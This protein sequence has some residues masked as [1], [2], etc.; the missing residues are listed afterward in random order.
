MSSS[1]PARILLGR[2]RECEEIDEVVGRARSG[3]SGVVVIEG[4]AGVGKTA[5]LAYVAEHAAGFQVVRVS[6]V[7]SEAEFAYAGLH[8][9][10]LQF[11]DRMDQLPEPQADALAVALGLRVGPPPSPFIVSLAVLSLLTAA[12]ESKP[13]LVLVDDAHW[14]DSAS[15]RTLSFVARRLHAEHAVMVF[16]QR[17]DPAGADLL[18][19]PVLHLRGL[20]RDEA[21][22]LLDSVVIGPLDGQVRDRLLRETAGNP[23]AL[24]ELHR[25]RSSAELVFGS[26]DATTS[27]L[28]VQ[29][30]QA[31]VA[32]F[33]SLAQSTQLLLLIAALDP[34]GDT[35]IVTNAAELLG[36]DVAL[37]GVPA[38]DARLLDKPLGLT[39][40]VAF[41]HPL[42]RSA[43]QHAAAFDE[44]Q[45]AHRALA[46]GIDPALHP[47]RR[48]WHRAQA[49]SG[50]DA[51]VA[52][53]LAESAERAQSRGGLAAASV[54][55]ERASA[56]TPDPRLRSRRA[57][58]A[59][60]AA[61]QA[62][63]PARALTL[64]SL[65]ETGPLDALDQ[66]LVHLTRG[67]LAFG[68]PDGGEAPRLLLAAARELESLDTTLARQTYL[69]A[70]S[71]AMFAGRLAGQ[72]GLR[73]VAAA[74][75]AAPAAT[76]GGEPR[77]ALLDGF[78]RAIA[79]GIAAGAPQLQE[80]VRGFRTHD[81]DPLEAL[82]WLWP[83][84][85]AAHDLWDDAAWRELSDRHVELARRLGALHILPIA[86]SARIG[87][88]LFAGELV[89]VENLVAEV[90]SV[91]AATGSTLPPY[92]AVALAAWRGHEDEAT[93]LT[94]AALADAQKRGDGLG[95]T[96]V[97]HARAVLFNGLGRYQEAF[98]AASEAARHPEELAF[99]SWA[100]PELVE[101]AVR[102]DD[103]KAAGQ[104]LSA[105]AEIA[106]ASG[107]DWIGGVLARCR[108]LAEGDADAAEAHF[109]ESVTRLETTSIRL[110]LA[111]TTLVFGEWLRARGRTAEAREQLRSAHSLFRHLGTEAFA[112]RAR[113]E[114]AAAGESVRI[115][116]MSATPW[117]ALSAQEGQIA[118]LA[119]QGMTNAQ[120]GAD[121]FVSAR[122]VEWHL[123]KVYAKLGVG[124]RRELVSALR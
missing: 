63:D 56:L 111:R 80:A 91:T 95:L 65:A 112:D 18:G 24:L 27:A 57:Y 52:T 62:G 74:A 13:L 93:R 114:L 11:L 39:A 71:A 10:C 44:L 42:V 6:G 68:S 70:L 17:P 12:A 75:L 31:Y 16:A 28:G 116:T 78:A 45:T 84:T 46:A 72:V 64:L 35:A 58:A 1:E 117:D 120:I 105:L 102:I 106:D 59:A 48:A 76:G 20:D 113:R 36:I 100:L 2:R 40:T 30:E 38:L 110:A 21:A 4:A 82:R 121:L 8:L 87:L 89:S 122:T 15:A 94:G 47:D 22:R 3:R 77:D 66:A 37:A 55:L 43:I 14:L 9:A 123:S 85:H 109:R 118:R 26:A 107:T 104:A 41:H 34:S 19:L 61:Q 49:T 88:H 97:L 32:R 50:M 51:E 5:L 73:E 60:S 99:A 98:S 7:E 54:F 108:G 69:E 29:L 115:A 83:A 124:S 86:L 53:E 33:R 101:A 119:L 25:G 103:P 92:G 67:Q 23:L 90:Q 96:L 79:G 81:L